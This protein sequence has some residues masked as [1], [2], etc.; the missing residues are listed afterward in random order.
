MKNIKISLF[1][2]IF[3]LMLTFASLL[4][5]SSAH[6]AGTKDMLIVLDAS[7]SMTD[8]FGS[9]SRISAA[10]STITS[11]L[12]SLDPSIAVGFRPFAN[13]AKSAKADACQVTNLAQPFTTSRSL[14]ASAVSATQAV[15]L[16]TPTAYTLEQAKSDFDPS[17]DNILILLTD[18]LE[19]CG[20]NPAQAAADLLAAG[21]KVKTYVIGLGLDATSRAQLTQVAA[22]GGGQYFDAT[23]S[24][25]LASSLNTIQQA[26]KPVDKTNTD[27]LL[28][29][30]VTGGNGYETAATI[31]P[32]MYHLSHYQLGSQYDYFKMDVNKGDVLTVSIQSSESE[33]SYNAKTNTFSDGN[34]HNGSYAAI[35]VYTATRAK[36]V[37]LYEG[38]PSAINKTDIPISDGE[39]LYFL[40]GNQK[41]KDMVMSKSDIFTIKVASAA[42]T[43][44][45]S[46]PNQNTVSN[47]APTNSSVSAPAPVTPSAPSDSSASGSS[48]I[49]IYAGVGVLVLIIIA[50]AIMAMKKKKGPTPP[51]NN[52]TPPNPTV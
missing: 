39:T 23:D 2:R 44:T 4:T 8:T 19:N 18:G 17:N 26:E 45:P 3:L 46:V 28:G 25:S 30:E 24:A 49:L 16:Y 40:V 37:Y 11:L 29:K 41:S 22:R 7:G 38:Q 5:A 35:G 36:L 42:S 12:S 43:N 10:K 14:I 48:N 51:T 9:V 6:A 34:N 47:T 50:L 13:V 31:T 21:I 52:T 1:Y 32:G 20:G 27:S 15:G 33:P